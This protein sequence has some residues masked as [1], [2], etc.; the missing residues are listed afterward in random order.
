MTFEG[1]RRG[2]DVVEVFVGKFL[3]LAVSM[4]NPQ[5]GKASVN[6]YLVRYSQFITEQNQR[7]WRYINKQG[8]RKDSLGQ[9]THSM[10]T[11]R[12]YFSR[13]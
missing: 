5:S 1:K 4:V 3:A 6:F 10:R 12:Y 9:S 13:S 7:P 8:S 2:A 11:Q